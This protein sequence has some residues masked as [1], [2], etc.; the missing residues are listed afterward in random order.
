MNKLIQFIK[1]FVHFL[2]LIILIIFYFMN[3]DNSN[4]EKQ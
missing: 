4:M 2:L 3:K 1:I